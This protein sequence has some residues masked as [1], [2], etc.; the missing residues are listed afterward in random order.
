MVFAPRI[1]AI[2]S[3]QEDELVEVYRILMGFDSN[4]VPHVPPPKKTK[5]DN[6]NK[7]YN[8][9]IKNDDMFV[10]RE[11]HFVSS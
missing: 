6:G 7:M 11:Y 2:N 5:D 4:K 9:P 1:S 3:E 8:S 10:I